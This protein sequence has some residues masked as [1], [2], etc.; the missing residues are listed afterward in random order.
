MAGTVYFDCEPVAV[1]PGLRPLI[2]MI[3][4]NI[5]SHKSK[6]GENKQIFQGWLNIWKLEED[7]RVRNTF[8]VEHEADA[9][10]CGREADILD[11]RQIVQD[12]FR[13]RF[14]TG[15]HLRQILLKIFD[16]QAWKLDILMI[17]LG[18][19]KARVI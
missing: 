12:D 16:F 4:T 7:G 3:R 6:W 14:S 15:C 8:V 9:P 1:L 11:G 18:R 2:S 10:D 19:G 5:L 17:G 13:L